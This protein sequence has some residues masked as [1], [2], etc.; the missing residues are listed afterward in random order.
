MLPGKSTR[1]QPAAGSL[2][3]GLKLRAVLNRGAL[4]QTLVMDRSALGH[5]LRPLQ[6]RGL[7]KLS[8]SREDR[9]GRVVM[10][11]AA[12]KALL[13]QA[14]PLWERA[15]KRF[16]ATFGSEAAAR[17]RPTLKRVATSDF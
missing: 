4:A 16:K 10:L 2:S 1:A 12:G 8:V 14:H 6:E 7:V 3:R 11:T 15:Q 9:R 5:L 17:L 13:P